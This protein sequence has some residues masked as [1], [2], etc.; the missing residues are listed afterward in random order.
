MENKE[1]VKARYLREIHD[2][3]AASPEH[4]IRNMTVLILYIKGI[5]K[6]V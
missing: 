3:L 1:F 2:L 4:F 5:G 6:R